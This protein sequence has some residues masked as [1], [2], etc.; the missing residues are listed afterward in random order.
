MKKIFNVTRIALIFT[1]IGILS[2]SG[3]IPQTHAS[4]RGTLRAASLFQDKDRVEQLL[5]YMYGDDAHDG[6]GVIAYRKD[7]PG[8]EGHQVV[9]PVYE[10]SWIKENFS[11]EKLQAVID[12]LNRWTDP[13]HDIVFSEMLDILLLKEGT[14]INEIKLG[15]A[16]LGKIESE[17]KNNPPY[18]FYLAISEFEEGGVEKIEVEGFI[19]VLDNYLVGKDYD[20]EINTLE[21]KVAGER[22]EE[23]I[24]LGRQLLRYAI[25][26]ELQLGAKRVKFGLSG[27]TNKLLAREGLDVR[28]IY[29]RK[30]LE[31]IVLSGAQKTIEL[32]SESPNGSEILEKISRLRSNL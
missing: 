7:T 23:F 4:S 16:L 12:A 3:S 18:R 19:E 17:L 15:L 11:E 1:L 26:K 5:R 32:L 6:K 28:R 8:K 31:N 14:D 27:L 9:L 21:V 10:I 30:E 20:C 29:G 25:E 22:K 2:I 13:V 24:G